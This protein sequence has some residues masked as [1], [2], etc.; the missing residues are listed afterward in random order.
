MSSNH[1]RK[2]PEC[3]SQMQNISIID[4]NRLNEWRA[5]DSVLVYT[6]SAATPSV[7]TGAIPAEGV[8]DAL[9]CTQCGR[10]LL[11]AKKS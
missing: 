9:A 3:A 2:C 8:I 1:E 4:R 7:W 5:L 6:A 10:V 11:Y